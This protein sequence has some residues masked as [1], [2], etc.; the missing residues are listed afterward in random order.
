[1]LSANASPSFM[2]LLN[3]CTKGKKIGTGLKDGVNVKHERLQV[4]FSKRLARRPPMPKRSMAE[5]KREIRQV[6]GCPVYEAIDQMELA[7]EL[8]LLYEELAEAREV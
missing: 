6:E 5:I 4:I 3:R 7:M 1:M 2:K 8:E